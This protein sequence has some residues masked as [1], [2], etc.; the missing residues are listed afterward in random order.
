MSLNNKKTNI[1]NNKIEN[2][3]TITQWKKRVACFRFIYSTLIMNLGDKDCI[4]KFNEE[5]AELKDK[6]IAKVIAFYIK[7]KQNIKSRI[8]PLLKEEWEIDRLNKVDLSIIMEAFCEFHTL[9]IDRK[10]IIDQAIVTSKR[11]SENNSYKFINFILDKLL[12]K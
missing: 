6:D 2:K 7:N 12:V 10:I 9:D 5:L 1:A 4:L 11:Y 3:Q 8:K